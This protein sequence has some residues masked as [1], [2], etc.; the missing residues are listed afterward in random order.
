MFDESLVVQFPLKIIQLPYA[1]ALCC[2][3]QNRVLIVCTL[4]KNTSLQK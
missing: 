4:K 1:K 2:M 3:C